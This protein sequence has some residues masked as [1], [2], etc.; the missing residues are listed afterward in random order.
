MTHATIAR[1]LATVALVF[2]ATW[3]L[4]DTH[5][6][7]MTAAE[8]NLVRGGQVWTS[9]GECRQELVYGAECFKDPAL[10]QCARGDQYCFEQNKSVPCVDEIEWM[11][12]SRCKAADYVSTKCRHH[13]TEKVLCYRRRD[14]SSSCWCKFSLGDIRYFCE[15]LGGAWTHHYYV[16]K[17]VREPI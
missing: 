3:M 2:L 14:G 11:N 5:A 1:W 12:P 7:R 13:E 15:S 16:A 8:Q 17:C 6:T 4:H 9:P 10:G